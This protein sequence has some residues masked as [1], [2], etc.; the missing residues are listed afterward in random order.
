MF[1]VVL[2]LIKAVDYSQQFLV[3]GVI[4]DFRS[5]KLSTVEYYWSPIKLGS[6]WIPI[7]L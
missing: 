4:P 3:V 7:G 2:P 5:F 1:E 6:I